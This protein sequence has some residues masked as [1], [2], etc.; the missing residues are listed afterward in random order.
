MNGFDLSTIQ[1]CCV[2]GTSA[3]AIYYGSTLIWPTSHDYSTDYFT[4]ESLEDNNEIWMTNN[5][6]Q[7]HAIVI[8][9]SVDNGNTWQHKSIG[10]STTLTTLNTNE[11]L[12]LY[13]GGTASTNGSY[14]SS[15]FFGKRAN[16]YGNIM[17]LVYGTNF[18][19]Q[20]SI[21]SNITLSNLFNGNSNLVSAENLILPATTLNSQLCYQRI[22][23]DCTSLQIAP[24]IF[25]ATTL[26]TQ[27]YY[28]A[29]KNCTSLQ[30]T[31]ILPATTLVH[32]CYLAMM[33]G[34][35]S[36]RTAPILPAT[37]LAQTCY[38]GLFNGCSNLKSITCYATDRSATDCLLNWVKNVS[39]TGTFYKD[40]NTTYPTGVNGIPSGWTIQ[41]IQ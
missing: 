39:S 4:I 16:V 28:E 27:C 12:L 23:K 5:D 32:G 36:L 30:T 20:T 29:F 14:Y 15:I 31:P 35:T 21:P 7:H 11:N 26:S 3:S 10:S 40:A 22:F 37:K 34:C 41:N 33:E 17:S 19:N 38:Q 2:G 25:P 13:A 24:K 6:S 9:F 8:Y 1:N 18:I